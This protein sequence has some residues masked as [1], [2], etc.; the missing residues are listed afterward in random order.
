MKVINEYKTQL[1]TIY[2]EWSPPFVT[3]RCICFLLFLVIAVW[4]IVPSV[5]GEQ[6]TSAL[7][8]QQTL[9]GVAWT[10]ICGW[11]FKTIENY[12]TAKREGLKKKLGKSGQADRLG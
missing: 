5:T 7:K 4:S 3:E 2:R 6:S 10:Q 12:E 11:D 1:V 9:N 8:I